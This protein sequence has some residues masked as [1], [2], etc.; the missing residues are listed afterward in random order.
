[1]LL[2]TKFELC[3]IVLEVKYPIGGGGDENQY[4][5]YYIYL[6]LADFQGYGISYPKII[7]YYLF[8]LQFIFI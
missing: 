7:Q 5:L 1:M 4:H 6:I 8:F 3:I 2:I